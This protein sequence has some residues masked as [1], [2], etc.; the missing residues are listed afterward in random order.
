MELFSGLDISL[1]KI[2]LFFITRHKTKVVKTGPQRYL[3]R[4]QYRLNNLSFKSFFY[5]DVA[6]VT[7]ACHDQCWSILSMC[8]TRKRP[9]QLSLCP[10]LILYSQYHSFSFI[11]I[12]FFKTIQHLPLLSLYCSHNAPLNLCQSKTEEWE[13]H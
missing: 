13:A 7:G 9:S 12:F 5:W 10:L 4:C 6:F 1:F 11:D 2:Y 3:V 8:R